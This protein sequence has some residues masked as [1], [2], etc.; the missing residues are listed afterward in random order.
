MAK[1]PATT[2][3]P[4]APALEGI[5]EEAPEVALVES[6]GAQLRSFLGGL[7]PF[8]KRAN[9]IEM[10]AKATLVRA[11]A[12]KLPTNEDEDL[13]IQEFLVAA[14]GDLKVV[15]ETW[16]ITSLV[17]GLH[18][19]LTSK[20]GVAEKALED[21]RDIAQRHH[22]DY[23]AAEE[24]RV[25][26]E[27]EERRQ[28]AEKQAREEQEAEAR[29]LEDEAIKAMEASADLSEKETRFVELIVAGNPHG[30]SARAA[31]FK[32][33]D[34]AAARLLGLVKITKAI[35]AGRKAK[36][37][38]AQAAAVRTAP[39]NYQAPAPSRPNVSKAA[40]AHDR[41]THG[42]EVLDADALRDA[43]FE[44]RYGIPRD[45]LIVD[46]TKVNDYGKSMHE[47]INRWPGVRYTKKNTTV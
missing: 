44:G 23:K 43:V 28:A 29:R 7:V 32:D 45:V 11:K 37:M 35:E 46:P 8:F 19:K 15:V 34:K 13:A 41:V 21:A 22:N 40:G 16:S 25:A 6:D 2:P 18:R 39:V 36:E 10:K 3:T 12:L 17:H 27:N 1:K 14:K 4:A 24:R 26:R 31:G 9:E 42:A 5:V 30:S 33:G 47:L 38:R 20:R